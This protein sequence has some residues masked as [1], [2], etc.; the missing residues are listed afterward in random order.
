[1][2]IDEY[3]NELQSNL[4]NQLARFGMGEQPAGNADN[5]EETEENSELKTDEEADLEAGEEA[6]KGTEEA[7]SNFLLSSENGY[8]IISATDLC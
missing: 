2:N 6:E 3:L 1:M 7:G 8:A 5:T 4:D